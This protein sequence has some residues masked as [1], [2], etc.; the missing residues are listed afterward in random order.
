MSVTRA[1]ATDTRP[2]RVLVVED[3]RKTAE[4]VRLYLEHAGFA[5]SLAPDG[6]SGLGAARAEQYDLAVLD[7][8]LPG[9]D[10]LQVCRALRARSDVAIIMLTA[11]T[12]E[13]DRVHGLDL[14]A[15]DY[16][17][18]PFSP[19]ELVAR[20]KAVLRRGRPVQPGSG[21]RLEAASIVLDEG[22]HEVLVR[23]EP[24]ALTR[25]EFA[26]L[27]ALLRHRG[28][29]LSR[30][31]LVELALADDWDGTG[32]TVDTHITNLRRKIELD[33]HMPTLVTTVFGVG[34]RLAG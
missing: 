13:S 29:V 9:L 24:V 23:G 27:R 26:I 8:M 16:V 10:G 19:R 34:Y 30:E 12:A 1:L 4:T 15:D 3:D 2:Q 22:T 20:V 7:I 6:P 33:R 5:V 18:K 21:R 32:R 28:R 14:G 17:T 31:E 11:R 25:S